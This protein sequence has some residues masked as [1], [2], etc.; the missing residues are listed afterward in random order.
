MIVLRVCR[1]PR[2]TKAIKCAS[3]VGGFARRDEAY[4]G[5]A[6]EDEDELARGRGIEPGGGLVEEEERWVDEDLVPDAGPLPLAS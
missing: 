5:E 4:L 3:I 1:D 6:L 2:S